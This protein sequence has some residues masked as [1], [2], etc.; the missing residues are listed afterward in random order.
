MNTWGD[1]CIKCRHFE[2]ERWYVFK[3]FLRKKNDFYSLLSHRFGSTASFFEYYQLLIVGRLKG[4]TAGED[5]PKLKLAFSPQKLK[6]P[7]LA[8][9]Q[10]SDILV[11]KSCYFLL[12]IKIFIMFIK[13]PWTFF[14]EWWKIRCT[15][16]K[17]F[18]QSLSVPLMYNF[19]PGTSET[20]FY[21]SSKVKNVELIFLTILD[22]SSFPSKVTMWP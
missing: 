16:L 4:T 3:K 13:L 6:L 8:S 22:V 18:K 15:L 10:N 14:C 5:Y 20:E 7:C 21:D 11:L 1:I 17:C 9:L 12:F 2:G 19:R